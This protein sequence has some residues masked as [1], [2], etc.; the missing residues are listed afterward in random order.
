[1]E[2]MDLVGAFESRWMG[3]AASSM[4]NGESTGEDEQVGS[5]QPLTQS[6]WILSE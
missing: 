2:E 1:M 6:I 3:G 5:V 4:R